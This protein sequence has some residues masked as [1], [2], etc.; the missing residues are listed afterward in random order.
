MA[1]GT[2]GA[3]QIKDQMSLTFRFSGSVACGI[4]ALSLFSG[5][6]STKAPPKTFTLFPPPPDEPRVQFLTGFTSDA[7]LGRSGSFV[8]FV[9]GK[10]TGP[11]PLI[12]PYGLALQDGK[13][14]VC[15]TMASSIQVFDLAR[16]RS[17]YMVT[18]AEGRLQTPINISVDSSGT[19]YVADTGRNQVV[20][21]D[22]DDNYLG[23]IGTLDEMRPSDVGITADRLYITDLKNHCVQVYDK[24]NRKKLFSIP[25]D[26]NAAEGRLFSPTNLALDPEHNRLLVSDIG[27]FTVLVYDLEG[28]FLLTIG[29][30]GVAPGLFARPKGV[31]V[32]HEGRAYVVDAATQVVQVFD[33]DGKLLM[34]FG[35]PGASTRGELY[36]PAAV[37][38]NYDSVSLFQNDVAPG[39]KLDHLILVTSQFGD[40]KV[41]VYGFL[42]KK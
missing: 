13:L 1:A 11:N 14:Y 30:Q 8:D 20:M 27:S 36:L 16:K 29:R 21:Y 2:A 23:A 41:N 37:K 19:R 42:S 4:L 24:A 34:F 22:K 17:R 28:K 12:K 10:P 35:Q 6:T 9:T 32:D 39:Y 40:P 3:K 26:S 7:D 33:T 25:R 38:I 18:R 15:D 31:T 5:C